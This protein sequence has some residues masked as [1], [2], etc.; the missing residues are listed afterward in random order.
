M[1]CYFCQGDSVPWFQR[2]WKTPLYK[3]LL[4]QKSHFS[5]LT[6]LQFV[7]QTHLI[8]RLF[9]SPVLYHLSKS[10]Q[11]TDKQ[12]ASITF[13]PLGL[14]LVQEKNIISSLHCPNLVLNKR[15]PKNGASNL[16]TISP[17]IISWKHELDW[18]EKKRK[19]KTLQCFKNAAK[20]KCAAD[21]TMNQ[22]KEPPGGL[23]PESSLQA[24]CSC[25]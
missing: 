9:L 7:I 19:E 16:E 3:I 24:C 20:T 18:K 10:I 14:G 13:Y 11:Q 4:H 25:R 5:P 17:K 21:K 12:M 22:C 1:P 8:I 2:S 15:M 23:I 6:M